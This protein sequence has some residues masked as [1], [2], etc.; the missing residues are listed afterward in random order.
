MW[1]IPP[2]IGGLLIILILSLVESSF[3]S[4]EELASKIVV[5]SAKLNN[6]NGNEQCETV[7]GKAISDF[8]NALELRQNQG[9]IFM[10]G[11]TVGGIITALPIIFTL[12]SR[13]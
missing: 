9:S 6:C 2:I 13:D 10:T 12:F 3:P 4:E 1:Q 7:H 5:E 8:K 11:K